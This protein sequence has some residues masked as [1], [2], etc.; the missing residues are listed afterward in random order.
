MKLYDYGSLLFREV[1]KTSAYKIFSEKRE[2]FVLWWLE[3]EKDKSHYILIFASLALHIHVRKKRY[4]GTT[5]YN[6]YIHV[7]NAHFKPLHVRMRFIKKLNRIWIVHFVWMR[8]LR[9][10]LKTNCCFFPY[11]QNRRTVVELKSCAKRHTH[12]SFNCIATMLLY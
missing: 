11:R 7:Y 12:S 4:T 2:S 1:F 10:Y 5:I 3:T 8:V 6:I 9:C